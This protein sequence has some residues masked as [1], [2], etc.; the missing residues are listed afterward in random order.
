[1]LLKEQFLA[2]Y[3]TKDQKTARTNLTEWIIA[4]MKSKISA[5]V[6][7]GN[8]F[9]RKRHFILTQVHDFRF[10]FWLNLPCSKIQV[11]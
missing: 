4:A 3:K 9:F 7:L 1:M 11:Q 2:V 10:G 6:E 8:K 5:F